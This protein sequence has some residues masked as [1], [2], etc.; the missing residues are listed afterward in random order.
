[1]NALNGARLV[2]WDRLERTRRGATRRELIGAIV[3]GVVLSGALFAI[4][5]RA[6]VDEAAAWWLRVT[7]IAGAAMVMRGPW[8]LFWRP[9]SALLARL[10]IDGAALYRLGAIRA[11]RLALAT[12]LVLV[13]ACAPWIDA[14][15]AMARHLAVVALTMITAALLTPAATT[16]GG[17]IVASD[18][19]QA[20]IDSMAGEFRGPSVAWLSLLA[21]VGGL[22]V[23]SAVWILAPWIDSGSWDQSTIV[24]VVAAPVTAIALHVAAIPLARTTLSAATREVAALDAVRL[25]H[26][27]LDRARGLERLIGR[28]AGPGRPVYEK[29]V[30]LAR[31]RFPLFY[32]TAGLGVIVAWI[33]ALAGNSGTRTQWVIGVMVLLAAH[34]ALFAQRLVTPPIERARL[35]AT[36]PFPPGAIRRAK[37]VYVTWRGVL[38]L[39]T[40]FTSLLVS[41]R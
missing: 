38:I 6:G 2:A 3:I 4:R 31:R 18:R 15:V 28:A 30:A 35:L 21:T 40:V 1:V 10:P 17:A 5:W 33:I 37:I 26:V 12:G 24:V 36:L 39:G 25:A 11:A 41:A 14:P 32:L 13:L 16:A 19:A 20:L 29:D 23:G 8:L 22:G 9:D 27:Q 7:M 34:L